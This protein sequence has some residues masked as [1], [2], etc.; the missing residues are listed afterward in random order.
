MKSSGPDRKQK[1]RTILIQPSVGH[2]DNVVQHG[3]TVCVSGWFVLLKHRFSE[4]E[5]DPW[6]SP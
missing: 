1:I 6:L 5:T 3:G 4:D 2:S